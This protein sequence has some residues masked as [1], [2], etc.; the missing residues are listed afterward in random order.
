MAEFTN[1]V[2]GEPS[3][4]K[5]AD[6]HTLG[7]ARGN[8]GFFAMGDLDREFDTGLPDGEYCDII[9]ECQ[10]KITVSNWY[11]DHEKSYKSAM[12]KEIDVLVF[13]LIFSF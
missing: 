10:Q 9:S 6:Y 2:A 4:F 12:E 5:V 13:I 1:T 11:K 3:I 7:M 8:K